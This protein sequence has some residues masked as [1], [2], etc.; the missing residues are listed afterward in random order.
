L[1]LTAVVEGR[2]LLFHGALHP[3]PNADLHLS[4]AARVRRSI[5]ALRE[6]R[7]GVRLGFFGHTHRRAVHA[8]RGGA[9]TALEGETV[10]LSAGS[11]HLVNPGSVG[12]PRDGDLRA[13]YAIFDADTLV[14]AFRRVPYD[15]DACLA[16][17]ARQGL[18]PDPA[19]RGA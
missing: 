6:G 11:Y 18:V 13:S 1:P 8:W 10:Q 2:F 12:Q 19:G 9:V 14:L 3:V 7:W 15:R 16:K 4:S 5:Q 17:A